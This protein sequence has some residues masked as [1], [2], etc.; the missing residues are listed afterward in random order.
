[1]AKQTAR[2]I[3]REGYSGTE[4]PADT[5]EKL[6]ANCDDKAWVSII[7]LGRGGTRYGSFGVIHRERIEGREY[8]LSRSG[9]N[10]YELHILFTDE[11]HEAGKEKR[12]R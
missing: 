1:M 12:P 9:I 8:T 11:L 3:Q 6:F 5:L 2:E 7:Y 10:P 4:T